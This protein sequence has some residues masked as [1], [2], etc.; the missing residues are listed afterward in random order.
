MVKKTCILYGILGVIVLTLV[1]LNWIVTSHQHK[2]DKHKSFPNESVNTCTAHLQATVNK[3]EKTLR[4][5][6]EE[7]KPLSRVLSKWC[8]TAIDLDLDTHKIVLNN[9]AFHFFFLCFRS[10]PVLCRFYGL[11]HNHGPGGLVS[12]LVRRPAWSVGE[13]STP[14]LTGQLWTRMG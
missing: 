8:H 1:T 10:H 4:I 6:L 2:I 7:T 12:T 3:A 11:F 5:P 13:W 9:V 14:R